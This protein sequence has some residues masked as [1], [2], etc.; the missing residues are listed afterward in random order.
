MLSAT[1][2][3]VLL[4]LLALGGFLAWWFDLFAN[5]RLDRHIMVDALPRRYV[6]RLPRSYRKK[7]P[8][9]VVI[10]FHPGFSTPE[11]FEANTGLHLARAAEKFII[12]YPEGYQRSWNAGTCCG[13][14]HRD[15]I[16]ERAFVRA[17]LD[18]LETITA[19]DRRR[20]YATGFSNGARLCYF[21]AGTMSDVFAAIAP[22]SGV[23]LTDWRP[24]RPMPIIHI[25]GLDDKFAPYEGGQS[26]WRNVPPSESVESGIAF[27]RNFAGAAH[28]SQRDILGPS[29]DCVVYSAKDGTEIQLC[30]IPGLGHHWPGTRVTGTYTRFSERVRL[31]PLGPAIDVNEAILNFLARYELPEPFAREM[32]TSSKD[33]R[34][35]V[36]QSAI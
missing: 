18:D 1:F 8:L 25:H 5:R 30:R 20:I 21:L 23:V 17:I 2:N 9:P 6:A 16:D 32:M 31:G 24:R 26:V 22:V 33:F 15:N 27:W 13:P 12:V 11:G 35:E 34:R 3:I 19:I 14:A 29:A 28:K 7:A 36:R 10:A 4:A